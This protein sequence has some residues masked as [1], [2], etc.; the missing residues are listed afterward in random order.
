[1]NK[2]I[3]QV[4]DQLIGYVQ[5]IMLKLGAIAN[6]ISRKAILQTLAPIT[7]TINETTGLPIA[8]TEFEKTSISEQKKYVSDIIIRRVI[9]YSITSGLVLIIPHSCGAN[10]A[11]VPPTPNETKNYKITP[12]M[13]VSLT[14]SIL[15][16]PTF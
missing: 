13:I 1:M 14:L 2:Y 12:E 15:F 9:A 5:K 4:T 3:K 6:K 8:R 11:K 10:S 7:L 16:A